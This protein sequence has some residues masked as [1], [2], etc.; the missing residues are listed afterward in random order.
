MLDVIANLTTTEIIWYSIGFL[1]QMFFFMRFL[2][3]WITSEKRRESVIPLAFWYFSIL[4]AVFLFA[5]A[6]WRQDPVI[7]LGQSVGVFIYS[8]N[9]YLIHRYREREAE[10][11]GPA[12]A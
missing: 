10:G 11:N 4:G 3:Q 12:A 7:I 9:L 8:R 2:V 1:G 5:Y 6:V